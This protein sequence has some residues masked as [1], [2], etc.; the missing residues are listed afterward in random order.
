VDELASRMGLAPAS[1][2]GLLTELEMEGLVDQLP[3]QRFRR[4]A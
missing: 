2:L 3:G 4:A 1:T